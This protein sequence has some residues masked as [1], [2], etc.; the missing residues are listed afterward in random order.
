MT[1]EKLDHNGIEEINRI[2]EEV[3]VS[4]NKTFEEMLKS[5]PPETRKEFAEFLDKQRLKLDIE[6]VEKLKA[7]AEAFKSTLKPPTT[8]S[9]SKEIADEVS[10]ARESFVKE[11]DNLDNDELKFLKSYIQM[12]GMKH[13]DSSHRMQYID[14]LIEWAYSG[15]E[16]YKTIVKQLDKEIEDAERL[17]ESLKKAREERI[18]DR[19]GW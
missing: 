13:W 4:T 7:D 12:L 19:L 17:V 11:F 5:Y 9:R 18:G 2:L 15:R 8:E 1:D 6:T 16:T 14:S 3:R 10:V